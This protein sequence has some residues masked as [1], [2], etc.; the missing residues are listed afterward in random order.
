MTLREF[1]GVLQVVMGW[2][3]IHLY[4]FVI[5]TVR[6]GSW[7]TAANSPK[8]ALA[9]L[10]LRKGSRFFAVLEDP[11]RLEEFRETLERIEQRVSWQGRIS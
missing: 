7:E 11:D 1:H 3:S 9:D 10:K 2:E 8:V 6:Y 4:Q 5:H